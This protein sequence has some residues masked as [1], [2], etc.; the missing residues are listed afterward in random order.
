[1][2]IKKTLSKK[3]N[4]FGKSVPVFA[5]VILSL[6]LVSAA[7]LGYY[8][9]ITGSAIVSQSVKLGGL[10]YPGELKFSF[11]DRPFVA[12]KTFVDC[13]TDD[14]GYSVKNYADVSAPIKFGTTCKKGSTQDDGTKITTSID[15]ANE[16]K[17]IDTEIYGILKLVKKNTQIW[18]PLDPEQAITIKYTI[19]GDT[20]KYDMISGKIPE[21]YELVYAMDKDDRWTNYASVVRKD[22]INSNLPYDND[23]NADCVGGP[24]DGENYCDKNNEFDDYEHCVGAKLW[25]V[26]T[27]DIL[28][29]QCVEKVCPLS[30]ANMNS[31]YY[32]TDLIMYSNDDGNVMDLLANGG[33]FNF[34]ESNAFALNLVPDTYTLTTKI[35]P[36]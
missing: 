16:C 2:K 36:A 4:I 33:G 13:D 17:G 29:S 7:L 12:G 5:I 23:W 14:G 22:Y 8:G 27:S 18:Q 1:M 10:D 20:F 6:A 31:Y 34:C 9:V 21:G 28:T 3:V 19:V 32:E 15:W 26:K 24:D 30:W 35:L 25:I 11:D